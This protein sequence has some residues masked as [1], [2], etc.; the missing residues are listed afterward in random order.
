MAGKKREPYRPYL[1]ISIT[2]RSQ[3]NGFC[4]TIHQAMKFIFLMKRVSAVRYFNN[5]SLTMTLYKA[6]RF[7]FLRG[8]P[9]T[10]LAA[11]PPCRF[12]SCEQT[13]CHCYIQLYTY[14]VIYIYPCTAVGS[15]LRFVAWFVKYE[16]CYSCFDNKYTDGTGLNEHLNDLPPPYPP[17]NISLVFFK[18]IHSKFKLWGSVDKD[19]AWF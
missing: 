14:N 18:T 15:D 4:L 2:K 16:S 12:L 13:F 9:S 19:K 3:F 5:V 1:S 10:Y 8:R 17:D 6:S 7:I 11:P